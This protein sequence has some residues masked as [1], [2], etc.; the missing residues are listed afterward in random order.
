MTRLRQNQFDLTQPRF[1]HLTS[2]CVRRAWL[3]GLCPTTGRSLDHRRT[4]IEQRILDLGRVFAVEIY[5]F[6]VMS[7]HHHLVIRYDPT[8]A[9]RWSSRQV[10]QRATP[11]LRPRSL[12]DAEYSALLLNDKARLERTRQRIGSISDF[13]SILN[14]PIALA[15][16]REDGCKGRFWESRA[17]SSVLLDDNAV[18]AAMVYADLN[19]ASVDH[20]FTANNAPYTSLA[21][22]NLRRDRAG[23]D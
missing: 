8:A 12:S 1:Y 6:A 20:I 11:I 7:N 9:S 3:C 15:A 10:V 21:L 17:K 18:L 23:R 19:A 2:R 16:N 5:A 13:M 14:Q 4:W 22:R